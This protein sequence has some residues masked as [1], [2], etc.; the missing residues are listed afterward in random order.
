MSAWSLVYLFIQLFTEQRLNELTKKMQFLH[1]EISCAGLVNFWV[2][3]DISKLSATQ[4]EQTNTR[5]FSHF[6]SVV[7]KSE[8]SI[9]WCCLH[10]HNW[11]KKIQFHLF[12][13]FTKY[14]FVQKLQTPNTLYVHQMFGSCPGLVSP[15]TG[16]AGG[17][18]QD[19]WSGFTQETS[20][21]WCRSTQ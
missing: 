3:L 15:A 18:G 4:S 8:S 20:P 2:S 6:A 21:P 7:P 13:S 14:T 12:K 11:W 19:L 5:F 1:V 16:C 10:F 9:I 17:A